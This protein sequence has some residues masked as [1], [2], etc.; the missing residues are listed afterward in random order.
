MNE[1]QSNWIIDE[2]FKPDAQTARNFAGWR[3]IAKKL[4]EEGKCI[5]T[6]GKIWIGGIGNFIKERP[7]EAGVDLVEL[8][9]DVESFTSS[10][11]LYFKEIWFQRM[12]EIQTE[13]EKINERKL[14]IS[15]ILT[16]N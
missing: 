4:V 14:A 7:Y 3:N 5:T 11:N 13:E 10:S 16:N 2:F 12:K 6:T 9:F 8:S 1:I 15:S